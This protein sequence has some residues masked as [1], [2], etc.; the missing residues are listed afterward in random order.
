MHAVMKPL[1]QTTKLANHF[2]DPNEKVLVITWKYALKT[3][4]PQRKKMIIKQGLK[5][6]KA[7][8]LILNQLK[9]KLD[10]AMMQQ[11]KT[12]TKRANEILRLRWLG[13]PP[14]TKE[15]GC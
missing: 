12:H 6:S 3:F 5:G 8:N 10:E 2:A 11:I 1:H 13:S 7:P 14:T 15:R 4:G 9:E